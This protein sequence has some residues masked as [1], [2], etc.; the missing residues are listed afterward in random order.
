M[1]TE[2]HSHRAIRAYWFVMNSHPPPLAQK[3]YSKK[4]YPQWLAKSASP[5]Q[6]PSPKADQN[7][8]SIEIWKGP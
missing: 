1:Q 8:L 6:Q 4:S 3:L 2:P 7:Q 5:R